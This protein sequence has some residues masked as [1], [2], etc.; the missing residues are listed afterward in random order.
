MGDSAV[1][2]SAATSLSTHVLDASGG[3]PVP[4]VEVTL[5]DGEGTV[6]ARART[7]PDGRVASLASDL[8]P[9]RYRLGWATSGAFLVGIEVTV[10]L[11]AGGH[12]H[13]PLLTSP[14]AGVVYLG[15]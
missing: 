9:G 3:G 8:P 12:Y 5:A 14:V 2:D 7:G 11:S 10:E 4:G 6:V 15:A 1:G 13:V